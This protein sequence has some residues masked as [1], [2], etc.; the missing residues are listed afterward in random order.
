MRQGI[1][2]GPN[3]MQLLARYCKQGDLD[4]VKQVVYPY[5]ER[6][7]L[8]HMKENSPRNGWDIVEE[9]ALILYSVPTIEAANAGHEKIVNYLI[10]KFAFISTE[11]FHVPGSCALHVAAA[12]GH[13]SVLKVIVDAGFPVEHRDLNGKLAL[14][15][16]VQ[17]KKVEAVKYL[18]S[19]SSTVNILTEHTTSLL[20]SCL[21][22][23]SRSVSPEEMEI[24]I[25]LLEAGLD[26]GWLVKQ[27][28]NP[29]QQ[30]LEHSSV[31]IEGKVLQWLL[32]HDVEAMMTFFI[33]SYPYSNLPLALVATARGWDIQEIAESDKCPASTAS[34]IL[35]SIAVNRIITTCTSVAESVSPNNTD[36]LWKALK[37]QERQKFRAIPREMEEIVAGKEL[38]K[39]KERITG[40]ILSLIIENTQMSGDPTDLY[41]KLI[42]LLQQIYG[43]GHAVIV[44]A[45]QRACKSLC[46]FGLLES[47]ENMAIKG[48][49]VMVHMIKNQP[50]FHKERLW[51]KGERWKGERSAFSFIH[52]FLSICKS[53]N[54]KPN[55]SMFVELGDQMVSC[56][57]LQ[58]NHDFLL[59]TEQV[60]ILIQ[61]WRESVTDFFPT[62]EAA[63]CFRKLFSSISIITVLR[64]L[65]MDPKNPPNL[66]TSVLPLL[67]GL[68]TMDVMGNRPLHAC[69]KLSFGHTNRRSIY[70]EQLESYIPILVDSGAHL[71]AV[72]SDGNAAY[73]LCIVTTPLRD[74]LKP[75]QPLPLVCQAARAVVRS[76]IEFRKSEAVPPKIKNLINLHDPTVPQAKFSHSLF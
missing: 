67:H 74:L 4:G 56:Y 16:A 8:F 40:D 54:Y 75:P 26:L 57:K 31:A 5:A 10:K 13:R 47:A 33:S 44:L 39:P 72:N 66:L 43:Q 70:R 19:Q 30:I 46:Q 11:P 34:Q 41:D 1:W 12:L 69:A 60:F 28:I 52:E 9:K 14:S 23:T 3:Q 35:I 25:C 2:I 21:H 63:V 58:Q 20:V 36:L 71:D 62:L 7:R 49:N 22:S 42:F 64:S 48:L 27:K 68:N 59:S 50:H 55:F 17:H 24:V 32:R 51:W 73:E 18:A 6:N 61:M 65:N 37:M 15:R 76:R 38:Q 45:M 53:H 29:V